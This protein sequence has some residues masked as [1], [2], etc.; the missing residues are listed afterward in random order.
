MVTAGIRV[1]RQSPRKA[2]FLIFA[3]QFIGTIIVFLKLKDCKLK[4]DRFN[5]KPT[6]LR[7]HEMGVAIQLYDK[8]KN[9][10]YITGLYLE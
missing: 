3:V 6:S 1:A 4:N 7:A 8:L 9:V 2:L 5:V 10:Y